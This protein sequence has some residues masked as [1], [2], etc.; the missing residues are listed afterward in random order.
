MSC[1][2]ENSHSSWHHQHQVEPKDERAKRQFACQ[3]GQCS[4]GC[5]V[6]ALAPTARNVA[7]QHAHYWFVTSVTCWK[8]QELKEVWFVDLTAACQ[9]L[10]YPSACPRRHRSSP[11]LGHPLIVADSKSKLI[12]NIDIIY[13]VQFLVATSG[14]VI[15]HHMSPTSGDL[16]WF[17]SRL[18]SPP[19]Y[20][21][22]TVRVVAG[23]WRMM[24]H[25]LG[26]LLHLGSL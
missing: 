21:R 24:G 7:D 22:G 6:A 14:Y 1:H 11:T 18:G 16:K 17:P 20:S 9:F 2:G 26:C 3:N 10:R 5:R 13:A 4:Q 19:L 15:C 23:L 8:I 25:V 12:S